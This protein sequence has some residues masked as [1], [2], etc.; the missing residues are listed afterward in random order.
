MSTPDLGPA[1]TV[2]AEVLVNRE[3]LIRAVQNG[4]VHGKRDERGW[5]VS[6][7]SAARFAR[8]ANSRRPPRQVATAPLD[9]ER[10]WLNDTARRSPA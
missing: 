1:A 9:S 8:E 10:H 4:R 2:A 3:R 5:L 7:S 6:R